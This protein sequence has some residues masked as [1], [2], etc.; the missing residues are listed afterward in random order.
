MKKYIS[1]L[2]INRYNP[3]FYYRTNNEPAFD[4]KTFFPILPLLKE[5]AETGEEVELL[6]L[7]NREDGVTEENKQHFKEELDAAG[8]DFKVNYSFKY[9]G[10][11][12]SSEAQLNTFITIT[13]YFNDGDRGYY[14][15][16]FGTKG[17]LLIAINAINYCMSKCDDFELIKMIYGYLDHHTE[18]AKGIYSSYTTSFY[19]NKIVE[20][21]PKDRLEEVKPTILNLIG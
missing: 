13:D 3:I 21:F 12:D 20:R 6:F 5:T 18:M 8:F 11:S 1:A 2:P 7:V 16:T 9:V 14:D 4:K 17:L 15:I 19:I 10:I